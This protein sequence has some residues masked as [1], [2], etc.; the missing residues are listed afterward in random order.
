MD[1]LLDVWSTPYVFPHEDLFALVMGALIV[2]LLLFRF[3]VARRRDRRADRA[4]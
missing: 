2:G 4:G 3:G 1:G